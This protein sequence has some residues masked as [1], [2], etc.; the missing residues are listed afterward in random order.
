M[1]FCFSS[2]LLKE[3]REINIRPAGFYVITRQNLA[4][5]ENL[6]VV[7]LD[8]FK[9]FQAKLVAKKNAKIINDGVI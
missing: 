9:N 6:L 4:I 8:F 3:Q 2:G 7:Y 5:D 1:L